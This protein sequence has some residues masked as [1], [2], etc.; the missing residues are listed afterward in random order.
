[1]LGVLKTVYKLD[2]ET[3]RWSNT[4]STRSFPRTVDGGDVTFDMEPKLPKLHNLAGHVLDCKGAKD[5]E[6][7]ENHEPTSKEHI[8]IKRS[9][10]MMAAYL[11]EGELNQKLLPHIKGFYVSFQHGSLMKVSHGLLERHQLFRCYSNI[12]KLHT[13]CPPILQSAIS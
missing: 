3:Y 10:E 11:K 7:K 12:S 4:G 2:N 9:A 6:E 5:K 1:M 13:S 8:N